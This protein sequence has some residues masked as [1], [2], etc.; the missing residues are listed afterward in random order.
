MPIAKPNSPLVP[1]FDII[2]NGTALS[3]DAKSHT[4]ALTVENDVNLPSLFIIEI[5]GSTAQDNELKWIDDPN[6][7]IG[8]SVEISLGY[9]NELETVLMGE[10]TA[11]EPEFTQNRSPSLTIRGY[12]RSHRLQRGNKIR[13]FVQQKDSDIAAQ[14]A[15]EN[16]LSANVTDSEVLHDYILQGNQ[17]DLDFLQQR[18][19]AINYEI[20]VEDKTLN[21]RPVAN[22]TGETL[23]LSLQSDLIEFYPSMSS[24]GQITEVNVQGWDSKEKKAIA[25][26]AKKGSEVSQMAGK[27]LGSGLVESVFGQAVS[28]VCDRPIFNQAEAD[29]IAKAK[30]N[31]SLLGLII[32]EGTCFGRTDLKAGEVIKID[33]ASQR[34]SGKYYVTSVKHSYKAARGYYTYFEVRRN[35]S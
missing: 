9:V 20:I 2:I 33:V 17:T 11:L 35:A 8:N 7:A 28:V 23:T 13:S 12:D 24:V 6:F 29:Q 21:F 15:R 4:I 18:A 27:T 22:A 25:S 5:T 31:Q 34:F 26:S 19:K 30:F 1:D 10:I 32:G 14:I 16:G 3:A